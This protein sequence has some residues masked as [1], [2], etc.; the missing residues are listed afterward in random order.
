MN[1][2]Q[3]LLEHIEQRPVRYVRVARGS[4]DAPPI[5]GAS[6]EA[7]LPQLDFD[8][9]DSFGHQE[10]FGTIWYEDGT[11]SSRRQYDG[12]EWWEHHTP[13]PLPDEASPVPTYDR[14]KLPAWA[15]KAVARDE[16]GASFC[17]RSVPYYE[18]G[19]W[20]VDHDREDSPCFCIPP[21]HAPDWGNLPPERCIIIFED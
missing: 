18:N 20:W 10:L 19:S 11:W 15:N 21:N 16:D 6:L 14:A 1:A 9:D 13:P 5:Q 3:E 7:L 12:S 2:K 17:F 8:Y 4:P